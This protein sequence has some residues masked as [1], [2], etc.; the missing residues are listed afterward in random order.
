MGQRN[1]W[2]LA[3]LPLLR[4]YVPRPANNVCF[5]EFSFHFWNE[6]NAFYD[7]GNINVSQRFVHFFAKYC[8]NLACYKIGLKFT[9]T[10][11]VHVV[12]AAGLFKLEPFANPS[13]EAAA[14]NISCSIPP[15]ILSP[16][17]SLQIF[18]PFI[19]LTFVRLLAYLH[20]VSFSEISVRSVNYWN[21][22]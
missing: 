8:P 18:Q 2:L 14:F 20:N 16:S 22:W 1:A 13:V 9:K 15:H 19:L 4:T 7:D 5:F 3:A 10:N 21:S 17:L 11:T 6:L 12:G